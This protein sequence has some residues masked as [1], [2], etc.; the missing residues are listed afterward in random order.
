MK[1]EPHAGT[2][3]DVVPI[4]FALDCMTSKWIVAQS[5]TSA[6][7]QLLNSTNCTGTDSCHSVYLLPGYSV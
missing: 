3:F 6:S 5:V 4:E 1:Y 7:F 2:H